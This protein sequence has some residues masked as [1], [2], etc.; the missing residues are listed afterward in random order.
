MYDLQS[1]FSLAYTRAVASAAG[2]FV[3]ESNRVFDAEGI[4]VTMMARGARGVTASPVWNY[5]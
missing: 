4:D 5:N 1:E 3:Q 2:F